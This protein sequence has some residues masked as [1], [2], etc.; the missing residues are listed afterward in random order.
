VEAEVRIPKAG[1]TA[2]HWALEALMILVSVGLAFG[3]AEYRDSRANHELATRVLRSLQTEVEQNLAALEPWSAYNRR[4]LDALAKADTSS[5]RQS[6]IDVYL[7]AR[8]A[9]PAGATLDTPTVRRGA[10]DAALSTGALR[11]IDYDV[12]AALR[13]LPDAGP[14]RHRIGPVRRRDARYRCLRSGDADRRCPA[15]GVGVSRGRL[16]GEAAGRSLSSAPT[17][18]S[19]CRRSLNFERQQHVAGPAEVIAVA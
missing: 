3:V 2:S 7:A 5:S 6:T 18:D 14:V 10:W 15:G 13:H 1:K 16:R 9:L 17:D 12:V 11:L 19:R 8:P 4:F